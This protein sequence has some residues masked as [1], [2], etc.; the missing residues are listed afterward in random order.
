MDKS[1]QRRQGHCLEHR[2]RSGP[3][4]ELNGTVKAQGVTQG[5]ANIETDI[6]AREVVLQLARNQRPW[7][8]KAWDALSK[9]TGRDHTHPRCTARTKIRFRD[10]QA[11]P[12]KIISSP[13]W[14]GLESGRSAT[15]PATPTCMS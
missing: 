7:A 4:E 15:T 14:S 13:T 10:I 12:R 3:A 6:D 8:V 1:R 5:M 9:I 2:H 11:Q